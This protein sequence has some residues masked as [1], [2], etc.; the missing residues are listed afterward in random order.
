METASSL[1]EEMFM[2]LLTLKLNTP[3]M[4]TERNSN[5]NVKHG[6]ENDSHEILLENTWNLVND[7]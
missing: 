4:L 3:M 7:S 2:N 6:D 5:L 1:T